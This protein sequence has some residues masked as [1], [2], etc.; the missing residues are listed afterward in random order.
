MVNIDDNG[1]KQRINEVVKEL[2]SY[3]IN[4]EEGVLNG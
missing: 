2:V 3:S 4:N 1:E